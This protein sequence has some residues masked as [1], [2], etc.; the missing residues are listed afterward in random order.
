MTVSSSVSPI[1]EDDIAE[2]LVQTPGFFER[3]A[4]LLSSIVISSPHGARAVSLQE[5]QS[6]ML[7]E[8]IRALEQ[9]I[10]G[11]VRNGS[12]NVGIGHKVHQWACELA[13][14]ADAAQLPAVLQRGLQT[15]FDVPQ[16]ALRLWNLAPQYQGLAVTEGV[17]GDVRA[18]AASLT[19]P[20]CGPNRGFEA[21]SW[22]AVPG[23]AQSLALLALRAGAADEV[24][25]PVFGLLVLASHDAARFD[26]DM[27]TDFLERIAELAA[28][29]LQ[30]LR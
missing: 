2:F 1:T 21:A 19:A 9:R 18:F 12:E 8:K 25:A 26:A 5:R 20:F 6:E 30:R 29:A 14:V 28:A 27:G 22:L 7:R 13:A 15:L 24:Q 3:H 23:Q 16:V 17:S 4:E 11:M 10:M